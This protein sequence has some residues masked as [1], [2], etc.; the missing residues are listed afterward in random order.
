MNMIKKVAYLATIGVVAALM[1]NNVQAQEAGSC[2][3][4]I[5]VADSASQGSNFSSHLDEYILRHGYGCD[6]TAVAG[7]TVLS[8]TSL[9]GLGK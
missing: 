8:A 4:A 1:M 2:G 6:I 5:S 3:S 7:N 9:A